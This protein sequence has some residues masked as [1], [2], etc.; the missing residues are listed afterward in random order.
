M[1]CY[2]SSGSSQST[3]KGICGKGSNQIKPVLVSNFSSRRTEEMAWLVTCLP[4][5]Q[6]DMSLI[7]RTHEGIWNGQAWW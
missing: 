3:Q 6:E 5:E 1:G 7:S 2:L 4:Y